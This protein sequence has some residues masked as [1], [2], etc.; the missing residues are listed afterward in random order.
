MLRSLA[1]LLLLA[2]PLVAKPGKFNK[3]LAPGD[4][5]PEWKDLTGTDGKKHAAADYKDKDVLVVVFTCNTCPVAENYEDRLIAFAKQFAGDTSKVGFVAI[6]PNSGKGD[7]L[8]DMTKRAK[9]KE[10]PFAYVS[11][12]TQ[13]V[14]KKYGAVYTP[15]FF[16]LNKDRTVVYTG[17]M[18]DKAPPGEA[19]VK[20]LEAAVTAVL[21]G[22][23]VETTE[24][25]AAAGCKIKPKKTEDD[26]K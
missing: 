1:V 16:V 19:T 15:E 3:V 26:D 10:F 23:K 9:K 2:A 13:E 17:A 6:N 25:S 8:D 24:T 21:A 18:D 14:T 20:H 22:K 7:T 11:D 4:A 5:A 12:P